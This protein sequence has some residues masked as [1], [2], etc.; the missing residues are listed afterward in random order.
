MLAATAGSGRAYRLPNRTAIPVG[1]GLGDRAVVVDWGL[2]L[3]VRSQ[4]SRLDLVCG[5]HEYCAPELLDAA[6][7]GY[8]GPAVDMW[9]L[10]V[11]CYMLL[12]GVRPFYHT[13]V[14]KRARCAAP[15][16]RRR[17]RAA[18]PP[19]QTAARHRRASQSSLLVPHSLSHRTHHT[20]TLTTRQ[21]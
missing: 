9:A 18:A 8:Y 15:P 6:S 16:P 3:A 7:K 13:D 12:S 20:P 10:G 19:R 1:L 2:A 5:S 21:L 17:R 11:T 14:A 4:G